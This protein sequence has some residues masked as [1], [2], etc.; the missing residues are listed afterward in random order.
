MKVEERPEVDDS[1]MRAK[2]FIDLPAE[3]R[4]AQWLALAKIIMEHPDWDVYEWQ[5]APMVCGNKNRR[6]V[7]TASLT[8][9]EEKQI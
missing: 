2:R 3:M 4:R 7:F 8:G 9:I 1:V 6:V 5:L